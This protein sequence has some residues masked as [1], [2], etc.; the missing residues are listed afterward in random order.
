M[1]ESLNQLAEL[2]TVFKPYVWQAIGGI[3]AVQLGVLV[4]SKWA[5]YR[6]LRAWSRAY[7]SESV[8]ASVSRAVAR[9][10]LNYRLS[11]LRTG[12]FLRLLTSAFPLFGMA[13]TAVKISLVANPATITGS[14]RT[15]V[16]NGLADGLGSDLFVGVLLGAVGAIFGKF[17]EYLLHC[18]QR[19]RL[20]AADAMYPGWSDRSPTAAVLE[21]TNELARAT[22]TM[23][24]RFEH[25]AT[26]MASGVGK[27]T[28]A[29]TATAKQLTES[30]QALDGAI[31][32]FGRGTAK[33]TEHAAT[34]DSRL[35]RVGTSI[36]TSANLA[37][38]SLE[39][40]TRSIEQTL[41]PV[42]TTFSTI[43]EAA[44]K[45]KEAAEAARRGQREA[46]TDLQS[47]VRQLTIAG[48]QA[49]ET[50][51][52]SGGPR[53][54]DIRNTQGTWGFGKRAS[55]ENRRGD[56]VILAG[57][58]GTSA[59]PRTPSVVPVGM[60]VET[61][62]DLTALDGVDRAAQT[63]PLPGASSGRE[64]AAGRSMGVVTSSAERTA[65]ADLGYGGGAGRDD[66]QDRKGRGSGLG[67][68]GRAVVRA[69]EYVRGGRR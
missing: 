18:D 43:G 56:P 13:M 21:L 61:A 2:S 60:A 45:L 32:A 35:E 11:T 31:G 48:Q 6:T 50:A 39:S 42:R 68:L 53:R 64:G 65:R 58:S 25:I 52:R 63:F 69:V 16:A 57:N 15:A 8:Q 38:A 36:E 4:W 55:Q 26:Q 67:A 19:S 44:D 9:G 22:Q 59:A 33:L 54:D 10:Q 49:T 62:T 20:N 34:F 5:A 27:L 24:G 28:E 66:R 12:A 40:A 51:S 23:E 3:L 46:V 30:M 1:N 41:A 47:L 37:K 7:G 14:A 29:A 17:C